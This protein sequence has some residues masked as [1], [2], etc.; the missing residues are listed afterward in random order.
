[1]TARLVQKHLIHGTR[2]FEL[3]DD[4]VNIRSRKGLK[5]E[6]LTVVLSAVDPKPVAK[7]STLAFVSAIS[8]E[9][10]IEFF[11]NKP[12]PEE[13]D[14]FVSKVRERALDEDFGRPRVRETGR[15]VKVEQ[16]QIAIDMLRTYVTDA[17][18]TPLLQSLEALKQDPNNLARLADMY[19]AFNG[20]GLIQGAVLN[21]A[22]YVGTLMSDDVPD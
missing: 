22:P 20:L 19:A 6:A 3:V 18:I 17:E 16:V 4:C 21:Y 5:D 1:M 8:R 10:L 9:P 7:G 11:V 12:T 15:T 13:F 14:A 2:E